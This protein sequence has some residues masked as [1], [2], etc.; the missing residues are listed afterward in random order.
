MIFP[1]KV[2]WK[3]VGSFYLLACLFSWPFFWWRD[4]HPESWEQ[5]ALPGFLKTSFYMWGPGLAA[6]I[7]LLFVKNHQRTITFFGTSILKSVLFWSLSILGLCI[8]GIP[9]E[10]W[11]NHL[12][13]LLLGTIGF[14]TTLGEELGWRGFLQDALRP[15]N[16][17][18]RYALIGVMWELWH[19]TNRTT[20]G[21]LT[22]ILI[23]VSI[24]I[25]ALSLSSYIIGMGTDRSKSLV[26]AVTFHAW[27]NILAGFGSIAVYIVFGISII[28]WILLL[29]Y[30]DSSFRSILN[31]SP[32]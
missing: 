31:L 14:F 2:N 3:A 15:L 19:F 11:N 20:D 17:V 30:W 5:L 16:P 18:K 21:E 7:I 32:D 23:R 26:V 1:E 28:Y 12:F 4:M 22:Q 6:I 10:G 25:L 8:C 9:K 24:F 13:P 29:Y 27:V